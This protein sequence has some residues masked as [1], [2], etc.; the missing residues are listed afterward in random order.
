VRAA[1]YHGRRDVRIEDVSAPAGPAASEIL[2]EVS[3]ASICGTDLSE[4]LHGPRMVPLGS[5]HPAS[6]HV[7]PLIMGHELTGYVAA[8]GSEV[9]GLA[10]GDR[11]V[12]GAANWCGVCA[13]CRE[14]RPN[15]C[16]RYFVYGLHA[17]GG[18]A[19]QVALPANMCHPVPS[20]CTADAAA[21]AQPLAIAL[22]AIARSGAEPGCSV[23][24]IGVGGIGSFLVA[25]AAGTLRPSPLIAIDVDPS[26][27][28]LATALG[29]DLAIAPGDQ[30]A[31]DLRA[32]TGD[33]VD[34]VIEASGKGKGLDLAISIVRNGGRIHLVGL[35]SEPSS[36][37]LH[38]CVV[39]EIDFSSSNGHVCGVDIPA[40]LELLSGGPLAEL[41][42]DR[43]IDL[44]RLVAD[45]LEPMAAGA[46]HGKVVVA[47]D[48]S[49]GGGGR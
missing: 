34:V 46:T 41:V 27:L 45:G 23:A 26:R 24:V 10:V 16:D 14:G 48:G 6:G 8:V 38:H 13:R 43:V 39:H 5:R 12:P 11:V 40:A 15:L 47:V 44:E 33:G 3:R 28:E 35:P 20:A 37:D 18:L 25:G 42:T 19:D 9:T 2:L 17:A 1:V 7:G 31:H 4:F 22:H 21:L 49:A 30:A 36:V 32:A 29:A